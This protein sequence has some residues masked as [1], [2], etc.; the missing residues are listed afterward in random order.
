M[1]GL[2]IK[3]HEESFQGDGTAPYL[4]FTGGYVTALVEAGG[5]NCCLKRVNVTVCKYCLSR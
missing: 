4:S 3:R 2:T 5:W 1:E